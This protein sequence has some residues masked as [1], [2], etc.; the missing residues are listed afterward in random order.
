M[1]LRLESL[2]VPGLVLAGDATERSE[3]V[4]GGRPL[5]G[6]PAVAALAVGE[7]TLQTYD[8]LSLVEHEVVEQVAVAVLVGEDVHGMP[9]GDEEVRQFE[10][11]RT[12]Q[13]TRR[14]VYAVRR[15]PDEPGHFA[16]DWAPRPLQL[17]PEV[18][19]VLGPAY[20]GEHRAPEHVDSAVALRAAARRRRSQAQGASP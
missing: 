5:A 4:R 10:R 6:Y 15:M 8:V 1:R 17:G 2:V 14:Q 13:G 16:E 20:V 9:T 11:R 19:E 3:C 7:A 12:E 18:R